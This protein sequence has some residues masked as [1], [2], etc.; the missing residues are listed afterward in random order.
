MGRGDH[1]KN[2]SKEEIMALRGK[3]KMDTHGGFALKD[4]VRL[5]IVAVPKDHK[6]V[7]VNIKKEANTKDVCFWVSL[8]SE[9]TGV[10]GESWGPLWPHELEKVQ[11]NLVHKET[12]IV[13]KVKLTKSK[14]WDR[15]EELLYV[16]PL[17]LTGSSFQI[18]MFIENLRM[19]QRNEDFT[20]EPAHY[21]RRN[22]DRKAK[23]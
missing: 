2:R 21:G 19:L 3:N 15:V 11:D 13:M 7:I 5:K 6:A 16:N 20:R 4:K 8:D 9:E 22:P 14:K 1:F 18:K 17:D 12:G 23:K 10:K